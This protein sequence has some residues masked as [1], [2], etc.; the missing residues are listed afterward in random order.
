MKYDAL[1]LAAGLGT[2]MGKLTEEVAKPAIKV[3]TES[4][5]SRL[6][7]QLF[8]CENIASVYV[9]CSH[10]AFS[11]AESLI[12][13]ELPP[14][15]KLYFLWEKR[16]MG[17]AWSSI[18]TIERSSRSLVVLHGDLFLDQEGIDSFIEFGANNSEFSVIALHK[19]QASRARSIVETN[20]KYVTEFK[21]IS[22]QNGVRN[23]GLVWSN[24][25]IYILRPNHLGFDSHFFI[26]RSL[27]E[28]IIPKLATSN[29]LIWFDYTNLRFSIERPEDIKD[30]E[31]N[32][33]DKSH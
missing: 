6:T 7:K 26:D 15:K 32:I 14:N 13:L 21:E 30:F 24:S 23:D 31:A 33:K 2:R 19:R 10:K 20:G 8:S 17:S 1:I 22:E 11:I 27:P 28:A 25:G 5:I 4:L 29:K 12:D 9:N 16:P 3:G 18:K